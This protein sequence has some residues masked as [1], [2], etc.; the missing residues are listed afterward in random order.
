MNMVFRQ[1]SPA[2][3]LIQAMEEQ[4]KGWKRIFKMETASSVD[5]SPFFRLTMAQ[6]FLP[7]LQADAEARSLLN[8]L[9][10]PAPNLRF[11]RERR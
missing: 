1:M 6:E 4:E 3:A 8:L 11:Y 9:A 10:R 2:S 7:L 5:P